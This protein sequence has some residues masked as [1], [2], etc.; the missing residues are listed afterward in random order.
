MV[1]F[2]IVT[3]VYNREDCIG[4]CIE[5]VVNQNYE[6]VEQWIVDDGSTDSTYDIVKEY[7]AK[8]PSIRHYRFNENRGVNTARNYAIQHSSK[9]F[10]IFLDSDDY[11]VKDALTTIN[12]VILAH[13]G[14]THYLFAQSD[15]LPYYNQNILLQ[16]RTAVLTFA[17][18][19]TGKV[20]GDFAHVIAGDLLKLFPFNEYLKTYEGLN[21]LRIYKA[22]EKQ[23]FIKELIVK[24]ER[25]RSD[26]VTRNYHLK[27]RDALVRQYDSLEETLLLFHEDYINLQ[28]HSNLSDLV[29]RIFLLGLALEKYSENNRLKEKAREWNVSIPYIVKL[30]NTLHLGF[31]VRSSIFTYS[32]LKNCIINS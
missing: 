9:Y 21:F 16:H 27:N 15:R 28:A 20:T 29:K 8:Y 3:P 26:S 10:I 12:K 5:S 13:F 7:A 2:T 30:L 1:T 24:R 19:L 11:L 32:Y 4:K 25:G 31:W 6:Y 22:E 14:Y 23:F 18:F 17:D